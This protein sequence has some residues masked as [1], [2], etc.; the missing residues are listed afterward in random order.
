MSTLIEILGWAVIILGAL[1]L[2]IPLGIVLTRG[3]IV[4]VIADAINPV[5]GRTVRRVQTAYSSSAV[6]ETV[7]RRDGSEEHVFHV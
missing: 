2:L 5:T 4:D 3:R 1:S 7:T 6:H